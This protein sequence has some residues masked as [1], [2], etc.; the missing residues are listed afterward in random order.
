[1]S[2]RGRSY[3]VWFLCTTLLP[4]FS[5]WGD[6]HVRVPASVDTYDYPELSVVPRASARIESEAQSESGRSWNTYLPIQL[7]AAVTLAAGCMSMDP[8]S[9]YPG[10]VGIIAGGSWL[11]TTTILAL[12]Y[13]PYESGWNEISALPKGTT[14]EQLTRERA[15]EA[16]IR[17]AAS[18]GTKLRWISFATNLVSSAYMLAATKSASGPVI[19]VQLA[20]AAFS[21]T[22]ILFRFH[23]HDVADDQ[24]D[25]KK[26]V[27]A[28]VASPT[29]FVDPVTH[30]LTPGVALSWAF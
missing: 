11:A 23:W 4:S 19:G 1:V 8:A 3:I 21:L 24:Q 12:A 5:A 16:S 17:S 15:A 13:R 29:F 2:K 22:P 26:R 6:T 25:Y 14:R 30:D 20:A 10:I 27:Y 9:N 7:S 28:P 18:L